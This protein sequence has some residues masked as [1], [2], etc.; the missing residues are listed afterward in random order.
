MHVNILGNMLGIMLS[1]LLVNML[2]KKLDNML[3][4]ILGNMLSSILSGLGLRDFWMGRGCETFRNLG[5]L[6]TYG[7]TDL[8]TSQLVELLGRS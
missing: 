5:N 8:L 3:G 7:L 6:R 4:Y 2:G 1:K